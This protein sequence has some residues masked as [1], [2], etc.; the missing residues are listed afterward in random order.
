MSAPLDNSQVHLAEAR[1][2]ARSL[3]I[4]VKYGRLYGF[5]HA[6]TATQVRAAWNE[7][8]D[9]LSRA[10]EAGLLLGV[11]GEDLIVD[12]LPVGGG[13]AER[14]FA[15]LLSTAKVASFQFSP[16]ASFD[17][18]M[19]FAAALIAADEPGNLGPA[20]KAA[21]GERQTIRINEVRFI[22]R[23]RNTPIPTLASEL[24]AAAEERRANEWVRDPHKL[25]DL[26]ATAE[27]TA[28]GSIRLPDSSPIEGV[29]SEQ[30]LVAIVRVL[31]QLGE[32]AN[33]PGGTKPGEVLP[34]LPETM[35]AALR[36]AAAR[37]AQDTH[38]A[39]EPLLVQVAQQIVIRF[40]L[41]CHRR[42]QMQATEVAA[43]MARFGSEIAGLKK[44]LT[45]HEGR[46]WR[47]ADVNEFYARALERRFWVDVPE[48]VRRQALLSDDAWC[49]PPEGV[50]SYVE[51]SLGRGDVRTARAVLRLYSLCVTSA[52]ERGRR[53]AASGVSELAALYGQ[54]DGRLLGTAIRDVTWQLRREQVQD[55][56]DLLGDCFVRLSREAANYRRYSAFE[57]SLEM[58]EQMEK[59][60]PEVGKE[61]RPRVLV[62]DRVPEFVDVALSSAEVPPD[63]VRVLRRMPEATAKCVAMRFCRTSRAQERERLVTVAFE[64]GATAA[65]HLCRL[66]QDAPPNVGVPAVG[67]LARLAPELLE[68]VLAERVDA[69]GSQFHESVVSQL[70]ASGAPERGRLLLALLAHLD[71][72]VLPEAIDEIGMSGEMSAAE[73]LMAMSFID[74]DA[75]NKQYVQ[76]KAIEALGRLRVPA[77][78]KPLADIVGER[79]LWRWAYGHELRTAAAEAMAAID[80]EACRALPPAWRL[81]RAAMALAPGINEEWARQRRYVRVMPLNPCRGVASSP[82]IATPLA[83]TSLSLSGGLATTEKRATAYRH[84]TLEVPLGLRRI[85]AEVLMHDRGARQVSF[86]IVNMNL[87]DRGKLRRFLIGQLAQRPAAFVAAAS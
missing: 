29:A 75:P 69:W 30:E 23:D 33:M 6:R 39:D 25:L 12:G 31:A 3:N 53:K 51:Q 47:S 24:A 55:I 27:T 14:A 28:S 19:R 61:L 74:P 76:V 13:V 80:V 26:I 79:I 10:G 67:L 52:D 77:A 70:A 20:L 68:N 57:Q 81:A 35:R 48:K 42:G 44:V 50:T 84:A 65:T 82:R 2:F 43:C 63:L 56:R 72:L 32:S 86:E 22:T 11:S 8:S 46:P 5:D 87:D 73:P 34:T 78:V 85:K 21:V 16:D 1:A 4:L 36:H 60:V 18:F 49:V 83:I 71:S 17:E 54:V 15:Q 41:R 45:A 38:R 59:A 40:A 66:L 58:L 9:V 62:N 64:M 37:L 7:L